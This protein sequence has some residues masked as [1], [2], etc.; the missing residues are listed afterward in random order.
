M[1]AKLGAV[2][3]YSDPDRKFLLDLYRVLIASRLQP[4][5]N[6]ELDRYLKVGP[7]EVSRKYDG[8]L[9]FL[10]ADGKNSML[11]APNGRTLSGDHKILAAAAG[12]PTGSIFAG[13]L[14]MPNPK[15]RERV[16]DV[17]AA[18]GGGNAGEG[19]AFG[20]FDVV[21]HGDTSFEDLPFAQRLEILRTLPETGDLHAIAHR[22]VTDA[23]AIAELFTSEIVATGSE[24]L[25]VHCGDGRVLKIKQEQTL[26][27]VVLGFTEKDDGS[28]QLRSLLLGVAE[29]DG[30]VLI[31]VAGNIAADVQT[32]AGLSMMKSL[33]VPSNYRHAAS[34]G[35]VYQMVRPE[36]IVE[37]RVLD[38]QSLDSK[39]LPMKQPTLK[40]ADGG[41]HAGP[42]IAAVTLINANALRVRGDKQIEDDGASWRQIEAY[43]PKPD[44]AIGELPK[45]TIVR[46][47]VWTK[48]SADKTD[49][50]KLV[51][52]K[53]NKEAI[54]PSYPAYVVHWTD[55]SKSRKSPLDR[56]VRPAPTEVAAHALADQMIED[57]IKKGWSEV[58]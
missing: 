58:V 16:G 8:E 52:W 15:G 14:Y 22:Q 27:L 45:S 2:G 25:V 6:L 10:L 11:V 44:A 1:T 34:T 9:W 26:D 19:L 40:Y 18:L 31:G 23:T 3:T 29:G 28:P 36:I 35:Q 37:T 51:V 21:R 56:D 20:V 55:Y 5:S 30:F 4:A 24:G 53:T 33:V 42:Q 54:D 39:G 38:V 32:Q 17:G 46:R 12:L 50:R 13:E 47:Q 49:V 41:W 57:N 48:S 43:A 7:F